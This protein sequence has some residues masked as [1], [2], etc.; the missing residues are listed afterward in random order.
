M[1]LSK[2]LGDLYEADE[3]DPSPSTP[4]PANQLL[5]AG[6]DW[7]DEAILDQAFASWTPG[8]PASAP[9]AERKMAELVANNLHNLEPAAPVVPLVALEAVP[10]E[11]VEPVEPRPWTKTDDDVL[12]RRRGG[13]RRGGLLSLLRR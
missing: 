6:P 10:V 1:D 11:P 12:P 13:G 2:M 9:A 7:A 3:D 4:P 5:G 8:P